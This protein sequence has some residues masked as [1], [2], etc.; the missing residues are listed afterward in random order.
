MKYS[1]NNIIKEKIKIAALKKIKAKGED[2]SNFSL[3][4]LEKLQCVYSVFSIQLQAQAIEKF[5]WLTAANNH[6]CA[7]GYSYVV[8]ETFYQNAHILYFEVLIKPL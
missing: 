7:P 4:R 3:Q 5:H 6:S 2:R 1:E 8:Y